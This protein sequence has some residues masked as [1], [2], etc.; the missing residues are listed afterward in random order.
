MQSSPVCLSSQIKIGGQIIRLLF[1]ILYVFKYK[2][3]YKKNTCTCAYFGIGDGKM[4][5][6]LNVNAISVGRICRG[7][8]EYVL[9]VEAIAT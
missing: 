9:K 1:F 2:I 6:G 7:V 8:Y 3:K 4:V 5:R